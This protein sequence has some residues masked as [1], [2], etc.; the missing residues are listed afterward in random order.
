MQKK[1]FIIGRF[2]HN[3]LFWQR[4]PQI[5]VCRWGYW[6]GWTRYT[7]TS[8]S[9]YALFIVLSCDGNV[10]S[11][12]T[13]VNIMICFL[14]SLTRR[15]SKTE[16]NFVWRNPV[17]VQNKWRPHYQF[18]SLFLIIRKVPTHPHRREETKKKTLCVFT[19]F[20][21]LRRLF[22]V[23]V[24]VEWKT[25]RLISV[26][27]NVVIVTESVSKPYSPKLKVTL[28]SNTTKKEKLCALL[29]ISRG[30]D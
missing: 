8:V 29:L 19:C 10:F 2:Q 11:L 25:F 17:L 16:K 12:F 26:H 20:E 7:Y 18:S 4:N 23:C 5:F 30:D 22:H 21:L 15:E 27:V 3:S 6:Y 1:W 14:G 9:V 24:H 28:E 13:G